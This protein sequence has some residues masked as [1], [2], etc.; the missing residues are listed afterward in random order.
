MEYAFEI[1]KNFFIVFF[2]YLR[3]ESE[4]L[5]YNSWVFLGVLY[6]ALALLWGLLIIYD[7]YKE[8]KE[9]KNG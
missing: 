6:I 8:K 4:T 9:E 1:L 5:I 3:E 7:E 2:H